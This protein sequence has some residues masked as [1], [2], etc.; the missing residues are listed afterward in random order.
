MS[1]LTV[2]SQAA[3]TTETHIE[4]TH[5]QTSEIGGHDPAVSADLTSNTDIT[6]ADMSQP[7]SAPTHPISVYNNVSENIR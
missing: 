6:P 1:A 7:L 2:M 3:D 4:E 5:R